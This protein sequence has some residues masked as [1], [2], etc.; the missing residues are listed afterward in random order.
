MPFLDKPDLKTGFWLGLGLLIAITA[1][2]LA[3]G[4]L[5]RLRSAA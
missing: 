4:L 5:G 1:W 2:A 3:T